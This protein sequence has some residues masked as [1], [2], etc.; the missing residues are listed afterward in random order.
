MDY[1]REVG[2]AEAARRLERDWGWRVPSGTVR[3]WC[4]RAGVWTAREHIGMQAREQA[5]VARRERARRRAEESADHLVALAAVELLRLE[6]ALAGPRRGRWPAIHRAM[7]LWGRLV[8]A[9]I[10]LAGDPPP[11]VSWEASPLAHA[12]EDLLEVVMAAIAPS[13]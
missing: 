1:A 12:A 6:A 11:H 3:S 2:P 7:R 5:A 9:E 8:D 13:P 10:A 4:S